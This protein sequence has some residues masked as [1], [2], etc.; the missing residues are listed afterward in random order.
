MRG[1]IIRPVAVQD[2]VR[3]SYNSAEANMSPPKPPPPATNTLPSSSSVAVW[4]SRATSIAPVAV[5]AEGAFSCGV[6]D[7]EL[8]S[9]AVGVGTDDPDPPSLA[10]SDGETA[11]HP[12]VASTNAAPASALANCRF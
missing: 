5:H 1:A 6:D 11:A 7:A 4:L 3:G 10:V 2:P 12:L 9:L 8:D